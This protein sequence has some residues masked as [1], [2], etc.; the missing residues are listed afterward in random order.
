MMEHP[1]PP[2]IR[3]R[4]LLAHALSHADLRN[5]SLVGTNLRYANLQGADLSGADLQ[6]AILS[7]AN[8]DGTN[9]SD[10]NLDGTN[11]REPRPLLR[12]TSPPT[13]LRNVVGLTQQQLDRAIGDETTVL[14]Y[15]L[16]MP[17]Q[18]YE[19]RDEQPTNE[20]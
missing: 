10:A 7:G 6:H 17:Q 16:H 19:I 18:W 9:L 13:D 11:L 15:N 8:L 14:P 4:S 2:Y 12:R 3:M 5:A 1:C 20:E